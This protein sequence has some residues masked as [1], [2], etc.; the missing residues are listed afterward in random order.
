MNTTKNKNDF[1]ITNTNAWTGVRTDDGGARGVQGK[2][3]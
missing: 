3:V 1:V 2:A